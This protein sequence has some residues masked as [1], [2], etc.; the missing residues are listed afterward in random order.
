M[1][2]SARFFVRKFS[3]KAGYR[4]PYAEEYNYSSVRNRPWSSNPDFECALLDE[5]IEREKLPLKAL[6]T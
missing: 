5:R 3:M 6:T 4:D 1:K 2:R